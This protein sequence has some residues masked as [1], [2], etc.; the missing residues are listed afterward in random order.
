M[1]ITESQ[2]PPPP[3][4]TTTTAKK[5]GSTIVAWKKFAVCYKQYVL[6]M[7]MHQKSGFSLLEEDR[8]PLV[9]YAASLGSTM[10]VANCQTLEEPLRDHAELIAN[11]VEE[12]FCDTG[13][14]TDDDN[15][16]ISSKE[17]LEG[18]DIVSTCRSLV[19]HINY[20]TK[21][22]RR[23]SSRNAIQKAWKDYIQALINMVEGF[24]LDSQRITPNS[25]LRRRAIRNF[26]RKA[27]CVGLV[28][29]QQRKENT[30][31]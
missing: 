13:K 17:I 25:D 9:V 2:T 21:Q 18:A 8:Q 12:S 11:F 20:V 5:S 6:T 29:A 26:E 31:I 15:K 30:T 4:P 19:D 23:Q 27:Q 7:W 10:L 3:P 1:G 14:D 28:L 22:R 24:Q 16:S